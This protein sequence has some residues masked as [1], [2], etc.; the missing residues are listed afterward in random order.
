MFPDNLMC[1]NWNMR[2]PGAANSVAW[3]HHKLEIRLVS[4]KSSVRGPVEVSQLAS[5]LEECLHPKSPILA[6]QLTIGR[7]INASI[8]HAIQPCN[9]PYWPPALDESRVDYIATQAPLVSTVGDFWEMV[10]QL[11]A[12]AI[13][14]LAPASGERLYDFLHY[15][16]R[17]VGHCLFYKWGKHELA[18]RLESEDK[19]SG[20]V[21]RKIRV[22]S[23][24]D[25][26]NPVNVVHFQVNNWHE[27][28]AP[29]AQDFRCFLAAYRIAKYKMAD[30]TSPTI[31]HCNNGT[32]RTG[33]FI[34]ADILK[35]HLEGGAAYVDIYGLLEQLRVCRMNMIQK[36]VSL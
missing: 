29:V 28:G 1:S 26:E 3:K 24:S 2:R 34:A 22:M 21:R 14:M 18:V 12:N 20:Y 32:G 35:S 27:N 31:V 9:D 5:Y 23:P 6:E 15:W 7:Y 19:Y 4:R 25:V 33:T 10:I 30:K 17:S 16:P 36:T 11:R 8:I 13:V